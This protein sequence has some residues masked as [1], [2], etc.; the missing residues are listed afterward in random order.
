MVMENVVIG[1]L[2]RTFAFLLTQIKSLVM[3]NV[4]ELGEPMKGI[5]VILV[6]TYLDIEEFSWLKIHDLPQP[7][8]CQK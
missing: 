1:N 5:D 6:E 8:M 3:F 4:T 7:E 2:K